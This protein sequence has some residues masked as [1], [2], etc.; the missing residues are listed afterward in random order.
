MTPTFTILLLFGTGVILRGFYAIIAQDV[1]DNGEG[2]D[3]RM[4]G[5]AAVNYG[6]ALVAI[7]AV[8]DAYAIFQW[9]WVTAI[10]TWIHGL[11]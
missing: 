3:G 1:T 8:I 2:G 6:Y 11:G 4:V 9:P 5:R 7:G 10:F